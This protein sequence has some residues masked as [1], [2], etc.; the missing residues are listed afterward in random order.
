ME[1]EK[2]GDGDFERWPGCERADRAGLASGR[3]TDR[4]GGRD[5]HS[6]GICR[7]NRHA[8]RKSMAAGEGGSGCQSLPRAGGRAGHATTHSRTARATNRQQSDSRCC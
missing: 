4:P 1:R 8:S 7:E 6:P 5:S 2:I 3:V